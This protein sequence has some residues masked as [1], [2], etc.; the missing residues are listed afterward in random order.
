MYCL[1]SL[2]C[3]LFGGQQNFLLTL[4]GVPVRVLH[5]QFPQSELVKQFWFMLG[6][7]GTTGQLGVSSGL[8]QRF[9]RGLQRYGQLG[10]HSPKSLSPL[11][12]GGTSILTSS[13][14]Q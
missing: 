14:T 1:S 9:D 4:F 7:N 5:C 10:P 13:L 2:G 6:T 3:R 11:R 12:Q 8:Q